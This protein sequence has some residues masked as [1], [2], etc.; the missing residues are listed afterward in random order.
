MGMSLTNIKIN[1]EAY[2]IRRIVPNRKSESLENIRGGFDEE[3]R[4]D[5]G[6]NDFNNFVLRVDLSVESFVLNL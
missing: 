4:N 2:R 5:V 1:L 3:R 6:R